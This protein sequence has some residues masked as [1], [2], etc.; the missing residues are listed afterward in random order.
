MNAASLL[1]SRFGYHYVRDLGLPAER[2]APV[3][4]STA[5]WSAWTIDEARKYLGPHKVYRIREV[6]DSTS[7]SRA[8]GQAPRELFVLFARKPKHRLVVCGDW[9]GLLD[10]PL[11]WVC[12]LPVQEA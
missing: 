11:Q 7:S 4:F 1:R 8:S 9:Y 5:Q 2:D 3:R 10:W 6:H 12:E